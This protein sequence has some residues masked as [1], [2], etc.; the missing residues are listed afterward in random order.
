MNLGNGP[1]SLNPLDTEV[2][3]WD[4]P[5]HGICLLELFGGISFR[6]VVILQSN[7]LIQ[8]YH[9]AKKDPQA[10]QAF[11]RHVMM[12]QQRYPYLLPT[13]TIQSYQRSLPSNI[14]LLK[15]L[16]LVRIGPID[17]VIFGWSCQGIS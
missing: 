16:N 15:M 5:K 12:L 6:L 4:I 1:P 14:T 10:K 3:Q 17:L 2:I 13:S 9:Y 8:R 11:M 7:I